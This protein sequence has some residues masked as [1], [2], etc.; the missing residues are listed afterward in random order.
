M[1]TETPAADI[2]EH[3]ARLLSQADHSSPDA[4][5]WK[6]NGDFCEPCED[7][8]MWQSYTEMAEAVSGEIA[9]LRAENAE[10]Q[11]DVRIWKSE[12]EG[13]SEMMVSLNLD[14]AAMGVDLMKA[15]E[16]NAEL[17]TREREQAKVALIERNRAEEL[18]R[19]LDE[20]VKRLHALDQAND[21][22][23]GTR[24]VRTYHS[25]VSDGAEELLHVLDEARFSARAFIRSVRGKA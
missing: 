12:A 18:Q 24:S 23:C 6:H 16:D 20:A 15:R 7:G 9:R 19:K 13:R 8:F 17:H 1:T 2:V 4:V 25:I 21:Q 5:R 14:R 3:I 22:L 10:L 11:D